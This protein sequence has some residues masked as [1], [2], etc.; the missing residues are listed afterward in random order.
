MNCGFRILNKPEFQIRFFKPNSELK[1]INSAPYLCNCENKSKLSSNM[2]SASSAPDLVSGMSV[3]PFSVRH[4]SFR[5][6][7][8]QDVI[9]NMCAILLVEQMN[10]FTSFCHMTSH[11][12]VLVNS[13]LFM[14]HTPLHSSDFIQVV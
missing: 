12:T 10:T 4:L 1:L 9:K 5:D 8:L 11:R 6:Q 3:K 14:H 7:D 2:T 13:C